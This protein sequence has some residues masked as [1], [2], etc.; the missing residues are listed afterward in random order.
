MWQV[1]RERFYWND[2][3]IASTS[4][5]LSQVDTLSTSSTSL[6]SNNC[7]ISTISSSSF[8]TTVL[9]SIFSSA[10]TS[11]ASTSIPSST[12]TSYSSTPVPPST[13]TRNS[14]THIPANKVADPF[15]LNWYWWAVFGLTAVFI[16]S[17]FYFILQR[18]NRKSKE[19]V[20]ASHIPI[21]LHKPVA[22]SRSNNFVTSESTIANSI[23][24]DSINIRS[25]EMNGSFVRSTNMQQPSLQ[26]KAVGDEYMQQGETMINDGTN[27][28]GLS[29][30]EPLAMVNFQLYSLS[31]VAWLHLPGQS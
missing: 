22:N 28:S 24:H 20:S 1:S 30:S 6:C 9:P 4:T 23:D 11:F 5:L 8:L 10:S 21:M 2:I 14:F 16:V 29:S 12:S 7:I 18:L 15:E 31:C 19:S 17:I 13:S 25:R 26:S 27:M 3:M